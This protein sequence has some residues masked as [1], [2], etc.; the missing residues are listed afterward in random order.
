MA[1]TVDLEPSAR[2]ATTAVEHDLLD[3]RQ[4]IVL[5]YNRFRIA[6]TSLAMLGAKG[7]L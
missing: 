3:H 4:A 2:F 7:L 5:G 1:S 6:T